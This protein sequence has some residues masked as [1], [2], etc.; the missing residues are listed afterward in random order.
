MNTEPTPFT[1]ADSLDV[2]MHSSNFVTVHMLQILQDMSGTA[3]MR[4]KAFVEQFNSSL[5]TR[6]Y[7]IFCS[8]DAFK[9]PYDALTFAI[10]HQMHGTTFPGGCPEI[11]ELQ[12]RQLWEK[13]A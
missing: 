10:L 8:I 6:S 5:N 12:K 7:L 11:G 13:V 4:F 3:R 1:D 2:P 9:V